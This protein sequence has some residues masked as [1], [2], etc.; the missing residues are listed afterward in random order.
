M[1]NV[2][3]FFWGGGDYLSNMNSSVPETLQEPGS[4]GRT[5]SWLL[6]TRP[7]HYGC[8]CLNTKAAEPASGFTATT[9]YVTECGER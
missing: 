4:V 3:I 8:H 7:I 9:F 1:C 6:Y 2:S 5:D